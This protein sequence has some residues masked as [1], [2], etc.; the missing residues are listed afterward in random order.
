M[1]YGWYRETI[2]YQPAFRKE[3]V[4]GRCSGNC[5]GKENPCYGITRGVWTEYFTLGKM[6]AVRYKVVL[7]GVAEVRDPPAVRKNLCQ[8]SAGSARIE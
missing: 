3:N 1:C 8:I 6:M 7:S 4:T 2:V 5:T